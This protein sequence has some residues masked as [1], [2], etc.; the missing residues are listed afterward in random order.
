LL[1]MNTKNYFGLDGVA[2]DIWRLLEDGKTLQETLDTLLEMY[3]VEPEQ[4]SGD[5]EMLVGEL[6]ES[7]LVELADS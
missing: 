1:D 4:L 5:L 7:G 3:E 2:G 6:I